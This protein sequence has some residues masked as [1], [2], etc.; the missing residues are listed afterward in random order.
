MAAAGLV[1]GAGLLWAFQPPTP[2]HNAAASAAAGPPE[3]SSSGKPR[4]GTNHAHHHYEPVYDIDIRGKNFPK[5]VPA[6]IEV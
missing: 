1:G 2:A 6:F 3:S 4:E 5:E